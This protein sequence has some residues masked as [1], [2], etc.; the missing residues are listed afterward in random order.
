[1]YAPLHFSSELTLQFFTSLFSLKIRRT[2]HILSFC[3]FVFH[4]SFTHIHTIH[5][6]Q[7]Y[8]IGRDDP[9]IKGIFLASNA[10]SRS[11]RWGSGANYLRSTSHGQTVRSVHHAREGKFFKVNRSTCTNRGTVVGS[12]YGARGDSLKSLICIFEYFVTGF[13]FMRNNYVQSFPL[14]SFVLQAVRL[15]HVCRNFSPPPLLILNN[16][17]SPL[18]V[19]LSRLI[20]FLV[21]FFRH[22]FVTHVSARWR[23]LA[24]GYLHV[25]CLSSGTGH[26]ELMPAGAVLYAHVV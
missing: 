25:E 24:R 10:S 21:R 26:E 20:S 18:L 23:S 17:R 5:T 1:V 22:S 14:L 19:A 16:T 4:E 8:K 3:L 2:R 7:S 13:Y 15:A 9:T 12:R 11:W 6:I